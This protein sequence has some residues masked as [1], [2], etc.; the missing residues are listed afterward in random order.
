[1]PLFVYYTRIDHSTK[2][3]LIHI[4]TSP[5]VRRP[6]TCEQGFDRPDSTRRHGCCPPLVDTFEE[7]RRGERGGRGAELHR[8]RGP[9]LVARR[10]RHQVVP[11]RPHKADPRVSADPLNPDDIYRVTYNHKINGNIGTD[12]TQSTK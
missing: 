8:R 2:S 9:E 4:L 11:R 3:T 5:E 7:S 1:M 6:Y 12:G 10:R